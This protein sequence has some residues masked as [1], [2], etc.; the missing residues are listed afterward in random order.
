LNCFLTMMV[1]Q[2]LRCLLAGGCGRAIGYAA[3]LERPA[4]SPFPAFWGC[5]W[6]IRR[7]RAFVKSSLMPG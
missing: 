1:N 3:S 6:I 4:I 2:I 7:V 5:V